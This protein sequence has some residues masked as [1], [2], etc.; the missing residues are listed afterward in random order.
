MNPG[1]YQTAQCQRS[2][3]NNQCRNALLNLGL[4]P[5][6]KTLQPLTKSQLWGR[7]MGAPAELGDTKT[8]EPWFWVV[9]RPSGLS[10][11]EQSAW[12][13][14]GQFDVI[15]IYLPCL[16]FSCSRSSSIPSCL[17]RR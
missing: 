8:D 15:S 11:E 17:G 10:Q 14:E 4:A 2:L 9:G 5:D 6:S 12:N 7:N 13:Y 16:V 1:T 3:A